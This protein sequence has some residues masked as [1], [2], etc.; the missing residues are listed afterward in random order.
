MSATAPTFYQAPPPTK[1]SDA[2]TRRCQRM[3]R[4]VAE[5][6]KRGFQKL[7]IMPHIYE[8]GTWRLAF[9]PREGFSD[10]MGLAMTVPALTRAPQ[11]TSA[12]Q[13]HPFDWRDTGKDDAR[14][15]ADK[16][17]ERFPE[18]LA[19]G[20]GRDWEYAGWFVELMGWVEAGFLPFINPQHPKTGLAVDPLTLTATPLYRIGA[21]GSVGDSR[22]PLPPPGGATA[23]HVW[24]TGEGP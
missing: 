21:G 18:L 10:R 15:L 2:T 12:S 17:I 9:G 22:C 24:G 16:M 1:S 23:P 5:L 6:H 20:L 7:R 3:L 14:A 8:L 4:M 11:Y 13:N 19:D